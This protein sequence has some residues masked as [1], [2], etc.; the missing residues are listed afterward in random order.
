[1]KILYLSA[2]EELEWIE[3][4]LMREL[5]HEVFTVGF[6]TFPDN[7]P[8]FRQIDP[9][10]EELMQN[11]KYYHNSFAPGSPTIRLH[12]DFVK[13]FDS[14]MIVHWVEN[15]QNNWHVIRGKNVIWRSIGLS[16]SIGTHE[17]VYL[18]FRQQGMKIARMSPAER[19]NPYYIGEDALLRAPVD[20]NTFAGYTGEQETVLTICKW[21]GRS[22]QRKD[23][24]ESVTNEFDKQRILCGKENYSI[25]YAKS[26]VDFNELQ[27]LRQR[28]RCYFSLFSPQAS[29]TFTLVEAAMTGM[30]I[31]TTGYITAGFPWYEPPTFI[32]NGVNG[33]ISDDINEVK[34]G[35]RMLLN[36]HS[37]AKRIGDAGRATMIS[38]YSPDKIKEDWKKFLE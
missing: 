32:E 15:I 2:H 35:I 26:N 16:N 8:M 37:L 6:Y 25:A 1:M 22:Q 38:I 5:G 18:R 3:V 11:F 31:I 20:P 29:N 33:L 28:S 34:D 12:P 21:L 9:N 19:K 14:V 7:N 24:Y 36:D 27:T 10:N 17:G 23:L 13:Q 4:N 30:P